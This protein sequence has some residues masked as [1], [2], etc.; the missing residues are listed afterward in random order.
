MLPFQTVL[1]ALDFSESSA[2]ALVRAADLAERAHADLHLLHVDPLFRARLAAPEGHF[3]AIFRGNVARFVN[4]TLG[5]DD[6]FDV[7]GAVPH[8]SHG[9][10]PA[11]GILRYARAIGADLIVMGTGGLR[12]LGRLL[13]GSVAAETLRRS[14]VPVLV[15]P[16]RAARTAPDP[17]CAALVAVDFSAHTRP[18]LRLARDV[19][20]AYGAPVDLVHVLEGRPET[21]VALGDLFGPAGLGAAPGAAA[22]DHAHLA[23]RRLADEFDLPVAGYHV[24]SGTAETEIVRL[25]EDRQSGLVVVGTH[26]RQGWDRVRLGSVAEWTTRHAPCP[27]LALPTAAVGVPVDSRA[28]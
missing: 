3:E 1:C 21:P 4:A 26:G 17:A 8:L 16:E 23:L 12:G 9:E 13:L 28:A 14:E 19:A 2:R 27:V 11:D 18:A 25:A 10:A 20:A 7:L 22:R 15:V 24:V 6:A 5:S